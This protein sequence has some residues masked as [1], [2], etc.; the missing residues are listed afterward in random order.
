MEELKEKIITS[1][2]SL[3]R[4]KGCKRVTMDEVSSAMGISK[5]TLYE[6]FDTKEALIIACMQ[7]LGKKI[8]LHL[9]EHEGENISPLFRTYYI[10]HVLGTFGRQ[11]ALMLEDLQKYYPSIF[12]CHFNHSF[13]QHI[14]HM[15]K[16]LTV[17]QEK[18]YLHKDVNIH[19]SAQVI[20]YCTNWLHNNEAFSNQERTDTNAEFMCN[21]IRGLMSVEAI[22]D[23]ESK[24][25]EYT[26]VVNIE[27]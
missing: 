15:E 10:G 8:E 14:E 16:W 18:N 7:H 12:S 23:F 25:E 2:T 22:A 13:E 19:L 24:R 27:L 1:A 20:A 9:S 5:R 4:K 26:K 3:F 11:Y 17:A 6:E 21:Y